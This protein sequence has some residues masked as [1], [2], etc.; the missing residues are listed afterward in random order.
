MLLLRSCGGLKKILPGLR[1]TEPATRY[2]TPK[3]PPTV[4][5]AAATPTATATVTVTYYEVESREEAGKE[6]Y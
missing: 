1:I 2:T 6:E 5:A 4:V 3:R